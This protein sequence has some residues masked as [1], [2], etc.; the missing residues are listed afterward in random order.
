MRAVDSWCEVV[1]RDDIFGQVGDLG[2][3]GFRPRNFEWRTFI[4]PSTFDELMGK[5]ELIIAHAGMGSI[6]SALQYQKPI[7]IMPRRAALGE[8]RNDHQL[9]TA[10]RFSDRSG[11]F[12]AQ[13]ESELGVTIERALRHNGSGDEKLS[14]YAQ[15]GLLQSLRQFILTGSVNEDRN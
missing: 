12:V 10:L 6:I 7:V 4:P 2:A 8:H 14:P 15:P 13:D 11:I 9:A 3:G 5:A 1:G